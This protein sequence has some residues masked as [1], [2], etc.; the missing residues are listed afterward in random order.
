MHIAPGH[1]AAARATQ[2]HVISRVALPG[3]IALRAES[4]SRHADPDMTIWTPIVQCAT[5]RICVVCC[6][7]LETGSALRPCEASACI[8][9]LAE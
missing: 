9:A 6:P 2:M 7:D 4:G 3:A 1:R 8:R 5:G